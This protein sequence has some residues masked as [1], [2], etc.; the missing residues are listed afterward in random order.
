MDWEI[1][2]MNVKT[3]FLNE[4]LEVEIYMDLSEDFVQED[5]EDLL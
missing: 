3:M 1:H 4:I 2:Q 5:K